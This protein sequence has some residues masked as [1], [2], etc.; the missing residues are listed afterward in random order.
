MPKKSGKS[1]S[2]RMT[3]RAKHK[4][5][6]SRGVHARKHAL[7]LTCAW[8]AHLMAARCMNL[9]QVI[10][11]VKEHHAKKRK[12]LKKAGGKTK[13]PKDPGLPSQWPFKVQTCKNS[14]VLHRVLLWWC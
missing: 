2:K 10:R 11:K 4:V 13:A 14:N 6:G 5:P 8:H 9:L 7:T 1:K 12:E 3:L